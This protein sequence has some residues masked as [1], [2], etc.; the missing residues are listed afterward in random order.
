MAHGPVLER[1]K[2]DTG[3]ALCAISV[4]ILWAGPSTLLNSFDRQKFNTIPS[5]QNFSTNQIFSR[6]RFNEKSDYMVTPA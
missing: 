6:W 3:K 4:T 5:S 2:S 1:Q